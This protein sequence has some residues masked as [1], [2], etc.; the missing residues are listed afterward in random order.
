MVHFSVIS[1]CFRS[2][3]GNVSGLRKRT[4]LFSVL[5]ILAAAPSVRA[6]PQLTSFLSTGPVTAMDSHGSVLW[7]G[8]QFGLVRWNTD[9]MSY[10]I[11]RVPEGLPQADI[12]D[13]DVAP[14]GDV[15]V[16]TAENGLAR[17]DGSSWEAY[18]VADSMFHY[19]NGLSVHAADN[20]M[21][22]AGIYQPNYF[23]IGG[24]LARFDG[25]LWTAT[26]YGIDI[27]NGTS[28]V[29]DIATDTNGLVWVATGKGVASV[30]D[31]TWTFYDANASRIVFDTGGALWMQSGNGCS[32]M[33]DGMIDIIAPP[34]WFMSSGITGL[35]AAPDGGI[36][37]LNS[38][39]GLLAIDNTFK[40][41]VLAGDGME[42]RF[43]AMTVDATGVVWAGLSN[44][45]VARLEKNG[46]TE[47]SFDEP[48]LGSAAY[49]M[50]FDSGIP[51]LWT[52]N[53]VFRYIGK[54]W[55]HVVSAE[56]TPEYGN[57]PDCTL[58][59]D[60][61]GRLWLLGYY[62]DHK[63]IRVLANDRFVAVPAINIHGG[64]FLAVPDNDGGMWIRFNAQNNL[65]HYDDGTLTEI[66][67]PADC[68]E[69]VN[70]IACDPE[71]GV[72]CNT[73]N[74]FD[75]K[76]NRYI[77]GV[78]EPHQE[79]YSGRYESYVTGSGFTADGTM[80]V[81]VNDNYGDTHYPWIKSRVLRK[82]TDAPLFGSEMS[83][84]SGLRFHC[85]DK[86]GRLWL[87]RS[88]SGVVMLDDGFETVLTEK[89]GLPDDAVYDIVADEGNG[90]WI[91]TAKGVV[92]YAD[93]TTGIEKQEAAAPLAYGM[94]SA[95]PN[96]FNP[97]TTIA[98]SQPRAGV[99]SVS[100][101]AITGQ[102]VRTLSEGLLT[103]GTHRL[104]WDGLDAAGNAAASGMYFVRVE[105]ENF[106]ATGKI[107]LVR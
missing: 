70:P 77:N 91:A 15:W 92:R 107:T 98:F 44:G 12:K 35:A 53:G 58:F 85:A 67:R 75:Q 19:S 55:E 88:S 76:F 30:A 106:R 61:G 84:D 105:A 27:Y 41:T 11:Y 68:P 23:D 66:P 102:K 99:A 45:Y 10:R 101:Y 57:D 103:A 13:V 65:F 46:W 32:R 38:Y 72:W 71:G 39:G 82:A 20:G 97:T 6:T 87:S 24:G 62:G 56:Y 8:T 64:V 104:T 81:S 2:F 31:S 86:R 36:L 18:G 60:T 7:C 47:Y 17:F 63:N 93:E 37:M 50:A 69:G 25:E 90:I 74:E 100:V 54:S 48:D 94:V 51:W 29:Y 95:F 42:K 96:P 89:Q 79:V 83:F 4:V 33:K 22:Y 16:A 5:C 52:D 26:R 34:D 21:V 78:W 43:T 73:Y 28:F 14:N 1:R 9:D 40:T 3:A 80:W 59:F 49:R